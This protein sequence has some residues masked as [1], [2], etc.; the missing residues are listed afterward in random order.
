MV[1][2][3]EANWS[4]WYIP[5]R[6]GLHSKTPLKKWRGGEVKEKGEEKE[7][8][9]IVNLEELLAHLSKNSGRKDL[10]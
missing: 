1:Y 10:V 3:F 9:S 4:T 5:G 8:R 6:A 7:N 2:K